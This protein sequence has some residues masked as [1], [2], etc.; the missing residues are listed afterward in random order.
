[1][2][3]YMIFTGM[4]VISAFVALYRLFGY[5]REGGGSVFTSFQFWYF[6]FKFGFFGYAIY[7]SYKAYKLF[8]LLFGG[9]NGFA[10]MFGGGQYGGFGGGQGNG[11]Q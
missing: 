2:I 3:I 11:Y 8:K 6:L 5:S 4:D 1:M 10:Q 9:N 7:K